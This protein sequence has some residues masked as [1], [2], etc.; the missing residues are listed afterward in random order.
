M[1]K[2]YIRRFIS[3]YSLPAGISLEVVFVTAKNLSTIHIIQQLKLNSKTAL[4]F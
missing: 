1:K 4:N 3:V 2:I